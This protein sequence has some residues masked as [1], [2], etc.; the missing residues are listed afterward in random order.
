LSNFNFSLYTASY[1]QHWNSQ[2][3]FFLTEIFSTLSWIS[4]VLNVSWLI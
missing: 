1:I 4:G 2:I 3:C